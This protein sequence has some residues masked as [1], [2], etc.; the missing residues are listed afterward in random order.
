M[1]DASL[2]LKVPVADETT[3]S[4]LGPGGS[5]ERVEQ[6]LSMIRGRWK[7][8]ILFSLFA[9]S[10][11]RYMTLL[12]DVRSVTPKVLTQNLR[13]LEADGLVTRTDFDEKPRR[14][15]YALSE[16]GEKLRPVLIGLRDFARDRM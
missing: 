4:C 6:T 9:T 3:A 16:D 13:E 11:V 5:A 10:S 1:R 14:V 15:E 8:P 7:L 2:H 12:R